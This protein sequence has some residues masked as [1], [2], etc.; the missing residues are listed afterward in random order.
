MWC[1]KNGTSVN[2]NPMLIVQAYI[3]K[4][5][6]LD[7]DTYLGT[8]YSCQKVHTQIPIWEI[9]W[10]VAKICQTIVSWSCFIW[11]I[12]ISCCKMVE[13]ANRFLF[14]WQHN[15]RTG[16]FG[17]QFTINSQKIP[18]L[19]FLHWSQQKSVAWPF[20]VSLRLPCSQ[21]VSHS[22]FLTSF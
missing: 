19:I 22:I 14:W 16:E 6:V 15:F 4:E 13:V 12:T 1:S 20:I 11:K 10:V 3:G 5:P 9:E 17:K 18:F 2:C 8:C 7:L 21:A